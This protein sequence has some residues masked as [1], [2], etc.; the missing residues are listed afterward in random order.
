VEGNDVSFF[1]TFFPYDERREISGQTH[2][3]GTPT[4]RTVTTGQVY[5]SRPVN[6]V[7]LVRKG[8]PVTDVW[9]TFPRSTM[10]T[11]GLWPG[12]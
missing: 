8:A 11:T 4:C 7:I 3:S 10:K 6:H 1:I 12:V 5:E 2:H 9:L